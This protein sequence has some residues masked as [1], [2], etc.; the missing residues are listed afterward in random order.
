MRF[1]ALRDWFADRPTGWVR[2]GAVHGIRL[3]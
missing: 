3:I 2:F 1:L